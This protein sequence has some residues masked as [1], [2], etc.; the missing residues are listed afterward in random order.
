M[1]IRY[2]GLQSK[3]HDTILMRD[4]TRGN[5]GAWALIQIL[6]KDGSIRV[7]AETILTFKLDGPGYWAVA[8]AATSS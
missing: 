2:P 4:G 3:P 8:Q 5:G 6:T 1:T 7:P